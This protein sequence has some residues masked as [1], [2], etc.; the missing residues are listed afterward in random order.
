MNSQKLQTQKKALDFMM[1]GNAT[2]TVRNRET[3]NR[4][5]YHVKRA[6]DDDGS[7]K[8]ISFVRVMYGA[9]NENDYVYIGIIRHDQNKFTLTRKSRLSAND[10]RVK[11]FDYVLRKL[12][13]SQLPDII[14]FWHEGR[15]GRCGRKL[16]RPDSIERG[17]GPYCV[18]VKAKS[19]VNH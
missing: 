16:T 13:K 3:G 5:T 2:F 14:E 1:G 17:F 8:D 4:Y 7:P 18:T 9:D 11:G 6:T 10:K 19:T 15:C 12:Q